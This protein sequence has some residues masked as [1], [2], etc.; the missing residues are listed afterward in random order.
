MKL[1]MQIN[2][3]ELPESTNDFSPLPAGKYQSVIKS[4]EAK[5]TKAGTGQYLSVGYEIT[6]PTHQGRIVFQNLNIRNANPKATEIGL[7]QLGDVL[8]AIGLAS[9]TD[10]DQL[11]GGPI[12]LTLVIRKSD[13]YGDSNDVKRV[14]PIKGSKPPQV[15]QATN[16]AAPSA[17]KKAPWA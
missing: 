13:E 15:T 11:I 5:V 14:A 9:L 4:C 6:G 7:R 12:E 10:T 16:E 1:D 17:V 8:R 2:V 3:N